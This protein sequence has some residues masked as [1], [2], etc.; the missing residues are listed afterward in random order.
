MLSTPLVVHAPGSRWHT[1]MVS[2][3]NIVAIEGLVFLA[4]LIALKSSNIDVIRIDYRGRMPSLI[5]K[6]NQLNLPILQARQSITPHQ[7]RE[8][9][10]I[11]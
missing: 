7:D 4:S 1:T 6:P 8:P 11:L 2:H 10:C 5:A 9:R 3:E